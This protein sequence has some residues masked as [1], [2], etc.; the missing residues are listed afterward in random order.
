[1]SPGRLMAGPDAAERQMFYARTRRTCPVCG[2]TADAPGRGATG[3]VCQE[4]GRPLENQDHITPE[5]AEKE[6]VAA[7]IRDDLD[8]LL[9]DLDRLSSGESS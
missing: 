2:S 7:F 5:A 1:M 6:A 8:S 3:G 9:D 4:C